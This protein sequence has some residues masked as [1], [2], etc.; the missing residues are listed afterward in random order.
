VIIGQLDVVVDTAQAQKSLAALKQNF[1]DVNAAA[2]QMGLSVEQMKPGS[3]PKSA[4]I[5]K[6][7]LSSK[8]TS[9]KARPR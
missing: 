1:N 3:I 4:P 2:K 9:P 8:R 5:T 6:N 7:S